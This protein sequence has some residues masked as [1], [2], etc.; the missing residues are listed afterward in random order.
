MILN[1]FHAMQ[2]VGRV[3]RE[4]LTPSRVVQLQSVLTERTLDDAEAVGRFGRAEE[5]VVVENASAVTSSAV[6]T[7]DDAAVGLRASA[8]RRYVG[9]VNSGP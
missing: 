4:E 8:R 6:L 1:S 5:R 2:Y 7:S 9:T 3:K